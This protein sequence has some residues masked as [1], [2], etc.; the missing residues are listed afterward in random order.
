[1]WKLAGNA[2]FSGR[3]SRRGMLKAL[4]ALTTAG[5]GWLARPAEGA[6]TRNTGAD[7]ATRDRLERA[8]RDPRR[9]ILIRGGTIISMD[10]GV[11]NLVRGDLLID[12][13]RIAQIGPDLS[14]ARDAI[15]VDAA[16]TIVIPG[17]VDPHIHAWQGQFAGLIPNS[18][19]V[20]GD[21]THNYFTVMHQTLGP[22]YLPEDMYI[23]NLLTALSCLDAGITCFCDNSH[24]SRSAAHA[25]AAVRA[26]K[27]SGVRA[28][29][30][31][32]G[33]RFADQPWDRQ[34]PEDLRRLKITHF[35]S[36]DQLVTMRMYGSG[37]ADEKS[38]TIRRELDLWVTSD[39]GAASPMVP[40]LY[41][42]ALFNGKENFNHATGVP[43]AN[44]A[45]LRAHGAKVNV[46][47]RSDSQ[48]TYGGT[49]RGVNGLQDA[50]DHGIRP[51][52][53]N[54]NPAA[55]G[56]DM[57][58]EM[59]VLYYTQRSLAQLA[60]DGGKAMRPAAVTA[61]DLL[62]F[63]TI[64]GAECNAV[65]RKCGS[66]TSGKE[67]DVLLLR[68]GDLRVD[69]VNN[70]I[71]AVVHN[72]GVDRVDT[73]FVAGQLKKWRGELIG[74]DRGRIRKLAEES[75]RRVLAAAGW[76]FDAFSD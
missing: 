34:W 52:I 35:P 44:W 39:G 47:P 28:V 13:A 7:A 18:N 32:G 66:L 16:G 76:S 41:E 19:G 9:R 64:R 68:L 4:G 2:G 29:Y 60:S 11:G 48:F 72:G 24:N 59:K 25:D 8:S 58:A 69:G 5:T 33:I 55:Y 74:P 67:A 46:C 36:D 1:M 3:W 49:G 51:G 23:G 12:G 21:R 65:E 43:E 62:E 50:L 15:V 27:E 31:A 45:A 37:V 20:D 75:R 10:P 63:A 14:A 53:S 30:A 6:Q 70:S 42:R 17:F 54:D 26:L 73:V 40:A 61:R 22:K 71:G 38:L 57:F 56:V